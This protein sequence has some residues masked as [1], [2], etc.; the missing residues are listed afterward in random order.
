MSLFGAKMHLNKGHFS[1]AFLK[2]FV[3]HWALGRYAVLG[4]WGDESWD[5]FGGPGQ[6]HACTHASYWH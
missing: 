3:F 6:G 5:L 4:N 1:R 2:G